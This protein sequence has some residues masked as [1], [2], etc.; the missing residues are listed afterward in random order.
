M[1]LCRFHDPNLGAQ[2][3]LIHEDTVNNLSSLG[4]PHLQSLTDLLLWSCDQ[5]GSLTDYLGGLLGQ[6]DSFALADLGSQAGG[7]ATYLLRPIERQE[8]WAAGVTYERSRVAR[9]EESKGSDVYDRVYSAERPEIFFKATPN[10]VVGHN[11][12]LF[13]RNDSKWM[14]PEPELVVLFNP[15]LQVI[16]YTVGNDLSSRD[17]EGENPIYIPQAKIWSRCCGLG[18]TIVLADQVEDVTNLRIQLEIVRGGRNIF[19]AETTTARMTRSISHLSDFL[20]RDNE[21]PYGVFLLTGTGVV[22]PDDFTLNPGDRVDIT[23]DIIG[24]LSNEIA[25]ATK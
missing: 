18:P 14:V 24:T 22:P 1:H 7:D 15:A 2:L 19:T 12:T 25:Y 20:G 16:G 6:A 23:I 5:P 9:R 17:I 11:E 3:G 8:V 13:I 4:Y 10:R 21:F